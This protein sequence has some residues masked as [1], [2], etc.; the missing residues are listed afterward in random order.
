MTLLS[1][2]QRAFYDEN[3]WLL[4]ERIVPA[5]WLARLRTAVDEITERTRCT[6]ESTPAIEL[7]HDHTPQRPS[8]WHVSSPCDLHPTIWEFASRSLLVEIACDLLGPGVSYRYG[9]LRFKKLGPTDRWHQDQPFDEL[10]GNA[11]LAGVHLHDCGPEHPRLQV[12][13]GSHRGEAFTHRGDDGEFLEELNPEEL[14]RIDTSTAVTLTAAAGSVEL[15]DYRTLHQDFYGGEQE[16]GVLLYAAYAA[17]GAVPIG[18]PRYPSVP[19][20]R[21]GQRVGPG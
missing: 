11:L 1:A 20:A 8:L 17:N 5:I 19:S 4:L 14:Q 16:G 9:A 15:L 7:W 12:I 6:T 21:V 13:S 10:E 2:E 18:P 3:G